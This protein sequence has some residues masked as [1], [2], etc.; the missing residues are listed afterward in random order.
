ML[1]SAFHLLFVVRHP[2]LQPSAIQQR[3]IGP[4]TKGGDI[5]AQ[6]QSGT[7]KTGA[8]VVGLLQ[9]VDFSKRACQALVLSPTR[10][11]ASQTEKVCQHCA[12]V[13][14]TL[15]AVWVSPEP[16][17]TCA[18]E[19]AFFQHAQVVSQVGDFLADGGSFCATFVGGSPVM[20]DL[21]KLQAGVV[22]AVGTPGRVWDMMKRGTFRTSSL[23]VLV[24]D[25]ADDMLSMTRSIPAFC[26]VLCVTG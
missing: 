2:R 5:I 18:R 6:A 24:L 15:L 11:L 9:R 25:E 19:C 10:E 17:H 7:G 16:P 13:C 22:V 21:R 14:L 12:S 20:E 23:K 3:A 8:F 26:T 4:F 1:W